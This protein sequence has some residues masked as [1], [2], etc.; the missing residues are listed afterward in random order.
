M[1]FR[2]LWRRGKAE[3]LEAKAP[4]AHSNDSFW[5][6]FSLLRLT[7]RVQ[8][9]RFCARRLGEVALTKFQLPGCGGWLDCVKLALGRP[10]S[11]PLAHNGHRGTRTAGSITQP[12]WSAWALCRGASAGEG[13]SAQVFGAGLHALALQECC[14]LPSEQ[15]AACGTQKQQ[16]KN[17]SSVTAG[18]KQVCLQQESERAY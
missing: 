5:G 4:P 1:S 10:L 3:V 2:F 7:G 15:R 6:S 12:L 18:E 13:G 16:G 8:P 14:V 11:C 9:G 17:H